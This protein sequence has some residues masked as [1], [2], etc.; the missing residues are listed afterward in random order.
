MQSFG[1]INFNN[2]QAQKM[3]LEMETDFPATPVVGRIL[4]KDK[5]VYICVD[6]VGTPV[7]VPLTTEIDTYTY[8]GNVVTASAT[9]TITHNLNTVYPLV[10]VYDLNHIMIHPNE[11]TIVDNNTAI[12]TFT[13]PQAGVAVLMHGSDLYGSPKIHQAFEYYQTS[14]ST[15]WTI[16]HDLGYYPVVRVF[17]GNTEVLPDTI[18][19]TSLFQTV[20]TFTTA[21]LGIA[22]LL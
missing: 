1:H 2:N 16:P 6:I 21:Q 22:R 11:V 9:W 7:W 18:T 19:H 13:V 4:F 14:L 5:R 15:T 12:I 20:I 17:I 10:Q 8:R 3:A